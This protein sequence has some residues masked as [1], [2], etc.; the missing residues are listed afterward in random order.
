MA[1]EAAF[2]ERA[3]EL[4]P[5]PRRRAQRALVAAQS[6]HQAGAPDAALRLLASAQTGPLDELELARAQLLHA[7]ITY[8]TT[9]GRDAPALLLMAAERLAPLDA[10]LAR[11][12]YLD[13]YTAASSADRLV[14][15]ADTRAVAAAVRAVD[16]A[17]SA[18]PCDVL[19]DALAVDASEG[20]TAG[21]PAL[22]SALQAFRGSGE[23][24]LRW[25][26]LACQMARNLGDVVVWDD[27]TARQLELARRTGAFSLLPTALSD[28]L[29]VELFFGRLAVATSLAA[30]ADAFVD[31][32]GTPL[33]VRAALML[34]NWRGRDADAVALI[35]AS[36]QDVLN[37]GEGLRLIAYEWGAT[38]RHN[39]LG[40]YED[41]LAAAERA[42]AD[43]ALAGAVALGVV[44]A[45]R[46]R[47]ALR[48][49]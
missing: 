13:A 34:A 46:G 12:S 49:A 22:K 8:A 48:Q 25:L 19:L 9:R 35:E 28:R 5:E 30:E 41:A 18:R 39:A 43:S 37:R 38:M 36:R 21:S 6:K 33:T 42:A 14:H 17:P 3:A 2:H 11:E 23:A 27:L 1:A 7:Q 40:R 4:T 16:W 10:N 24:D 20:V 45:H 31:A 15:D 47:G 44:R 26:S 32:T 29:R